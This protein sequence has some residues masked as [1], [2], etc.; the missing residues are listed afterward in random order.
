MLLWVSQALEN[1]ITTTGVV[2]CKKWCCFA[3]FLTILEKEWQ[4]FCNGGL[5]KFKEWNNLEKEK[6]HC[7]VGSQNTTTTDAEH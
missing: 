4:N 5:T 6:K 7:E 1:E 2:I 3:T